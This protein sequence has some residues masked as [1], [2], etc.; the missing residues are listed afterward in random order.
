MTVS[1]QSAVAELPR[2]RAEDARRLA[3]L[4]VATVADLLLALPFDWEEYGGPVELAGVQPGEAATVVGTITAISARRARNRNLRM[5]EASVRDERGAVLKVVWF[6]QPYLA[7]QLERGDRV[8]LAGKLKA[9]GYGGLQM[10]NPHLEKLPDG[11]DGG[12]RRIGG[13]MPKY[14]LT[15]GLSSRRVA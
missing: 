13:M 12:P 6:N 9:A 10:L 2:A 5:T 4:G 7:G 1:L 15:Q 8:A 14:H 3:R 11:P